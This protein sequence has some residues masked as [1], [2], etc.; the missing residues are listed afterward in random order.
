LPRVQ[1]LFEARNPKGEAIISDIDGRVE[2]L[3]TEDGGRMLK[4]I[5]SEMREDVPD[6]PGNWAILV[7]DGDEVSA[8]MRLAKR[9]DKEILSEHAGIVQRDGRKIVVRWEFK[10]EYEYEVASAARLRV[11]TGGAV[12]AGQQ[13]TEGSNNPNRIL[14]IMGREAAQ[15]YLMEEVQR[16][17]RSQGVSIHDKHIELIVRQ[18]T[19]YQRGQ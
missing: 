11:E 14:R 4:V 16:V 6:I 5:F 19:I 12:T 2:S 7:E 8:R 13:L 3:S 17:Y 9:G 10:D 18:M 15:V 1:E